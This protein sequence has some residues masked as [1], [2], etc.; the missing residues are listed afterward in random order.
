MNEV[1]ERLRAVSLPLLEEL[2]TAW[3]S[4]CDASQHFEPRL[5]DSGNL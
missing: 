1:W 2:G 3:E 4:V 5:D